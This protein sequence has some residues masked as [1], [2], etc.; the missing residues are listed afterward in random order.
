MYDR[1]SDLV[2]KWWMSV[3]NLNERNK[4]EASENSVYIATDPAQIIVKSNAL[5]Y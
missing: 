4:V 1:F 3:E 5:D 2:A